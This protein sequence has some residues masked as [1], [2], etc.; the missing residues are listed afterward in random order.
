MRSYPFTVVL[1]A[2]LCRTCDTIPS[3]HCST[4]SLLPVPKCQ[5]LISPLLSVRHSLSLQA[6]AIL[7]HACDRIRRVTARESPRPGRPRSWAR[8]NP[9]MGRR[10][11]SRVRPGQVADAMRV[12]A[13]VAPRVAS[14]DRAAS[15]GKPAGGCSSFKRRVEREERCAAPHALTALGACVRARRWAGR[16]VWAGKWGRRRLRARGVAAA[17]CR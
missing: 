12:R 5:K 6:T 15:K 4:V 7:Q 11:P 10:G 14:G 13:G 17:T 8:C 2:V 1:Y 3:I 16:R 9:R